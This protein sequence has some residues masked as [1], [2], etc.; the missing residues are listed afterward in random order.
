MK[1]MSLNTNQEII[2]SIIG[3]IYVDISFLF[4]FLLMKPFVCICFYHEL[5]IKESTKIINA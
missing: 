1:L 4:F 2:N 3:V 5:V